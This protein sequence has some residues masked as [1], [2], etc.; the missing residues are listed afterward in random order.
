MKFTPRHEIRRQVARAFSEMYGAE[1]PEYQR[2]VAPVRESNLRE[3]ANNQDFVMN[4][5]AIIEE[6]HG[7]IRVPGAMEMRI[8]T[9]I[10]AQ[11]GM[12]PVEFY[13]MTILG[14]KS[15]PMTATA[16]RPIDHTINQS[17]FRMFCSM[18]HAE[19]IPQV[20]REEVLAELE[21]NRKRFPKFSE[22]LLGL[23][24]T[25]EAQA[26]MAAAEVE[27]FVREVVDSFSMHREKV[28]NF[29]LYSR[30]RIVSDPLADI[31]LE[32]PV[33]NH[34]TPRALD[35]RDAVTG[36]VESGIPMQNVIQ[37]PP[38]REDGVNIQLNQIA[39][40]A[41]G[42]DVY[43]TLDPKLLYIL[44]ND[45]ASLADLKAAAPKI[46]LHNGEKV[47]D[48]MAR[49]KEVLKTNKLAV[50]QH[51][52]RFGEI[53]SRGVAL[54][55]E[56]EQAYNAYGIESETDSTRKK[57]KIEK[58]KR[59]YPKTHEEL[60]RKGWAYYTYQVSDA[61]HGW[62]GNEN[63]GL[64]PADVLLDRGYI[65]LVPQTYNDFLPFSAAA[66]FTANLT[67][68]TEGIGEASQAAASRNR[69]A[70]EKAIGTPILSRHHLHREETDESL[71]QVQDA[72]RSKDNSRSEIHEK[73]SSR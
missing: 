16:F 15:L 8:V 27:T 50:I 53:E 6:K 3:I 20:L 67:T 65:K 32:S 62:N 21:T 5:E 12:H 55:V 17:S 1:L 22:R 49:I 61:D 13:D 72:L 64:L 38:I 54:T 28:V 40:I 43:V 34:L 71:R 31:V 70:L 51:K 63:L 30:L 47:G 35:I 56:G 7:A 29:D 23:L 24:A 60:H 41:A 69:A 73:A 10:F 2:F 9:R 37:G 52:A 18:L 58:F 68:G 59:E 26:G 57:E 46:R 45:S 44:Q 33:L 48:Y 14:E 25:A 4:Q 36:L 11:M 66:I 42:E 19:S 39:R